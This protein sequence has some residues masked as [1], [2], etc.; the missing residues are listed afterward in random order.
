MVG[1]AEPCAQVCPHVPRGT[2]VVGRA[3]PCAQVCLHVTVPPAEG[4][5]CGGLSR[6]SC[7]GHRTEGGSSR[8][9][10]HC[11][12]WPTATG[13]PVHTQDISE[14]PCAL[15]RSEYIIPEEHSLT[16]TVL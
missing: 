7:P 5:H 11:P 16:G 4:D 13:S 15:N 14:A 3:E 12:R 9:P 10:P 1:R 6:V 8:P 2:S